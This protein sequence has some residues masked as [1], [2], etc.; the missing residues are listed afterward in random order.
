M[1]SSPSIL[2]NKE[3]KLKFQTQSKYLLGA[4]DEEIRSF[5]SENKNFLLELSIAWKKKGINKEIFN[6]LKYSGYGP[7]LFIEFHKK[8][9]LNE[10]NIFFPAICD[11]SDFL[12]NG[13]HFFFSEAFGKRVYESGCV[14]MILR[15][16]LTH[17]KFSIKHLL[18]SALD[19]QYT[20]SS[21]NRT[22]LVDNYLGIMNNVLRLNED[23]Y[24][25]VRNMGAINLFQSFLQQMNE[26]DKEK[27]NMRI[28]AFCNI[29][30]A[31]I[32][33]EEEKKMIEIS[34]SALKFLVDFLQGALMSP[35]HTCH[36]YCVGEI[37]FALNKLARSDENKK[38]IKEYITLLGKAL[39][40]AES[41]LEEKN[42]IECLWTLSFDEECK[43]IIQNDHRDIIENLSYSAKSEQIMS[44]AKNLI[45]QL[46]K[47]EKVKKHENQK[48]DE[49]NGHVMISYNW[50]HKSTAQKIKKFLT[51]RGFKIWID[52]DNMGKST[53]DS[54]VEAIENAYAVIICFS[55]QYYNSNAC[56][57]GNIL[58]LHNI[59]FFFFFI[60]HK[61]HNSV[62]LQRLTTLINYKR[63]SYQL[64][65]NKVINQ[66]N[67]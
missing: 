24:T 23:L 36:G 8:F 59:Q 46:N 18:N 39:E 27:V 43:E 51:K 49:R 61:I 56:R 17:K 52:V 33:T 42:A 34:D 1:G 5:Y 50:T 22:E 3:E 4:N 15:E 35:T 40:Q 19:S 45:F 13:S 47:S 54:M 53:V 11:I 29:L 28:K 30:L 48:V 67:G 60:L 16:I 26:L 20:M 65:F 7:K 58:F 64:E 44:I 55:E 37:I 32:I 9:F 66:L 38:K 12:I 25:K 57:S 2:V 63:K 41:I 14:Q 62:L 21:A 31:Y 10:E 6:D